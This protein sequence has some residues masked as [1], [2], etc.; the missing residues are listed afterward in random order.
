MA[1]TQGQGQ[2]VYFLLN[3]SPPELLDVAIS[4]FVGAKVI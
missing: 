4:N 3:A 1:L 2:I